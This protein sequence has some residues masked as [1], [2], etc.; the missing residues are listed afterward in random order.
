MIELTEEYRVAAKEY[1][2]KFGYGVPLSMIPP[3]VNTSD[4]IQQIREC[5]EKGKD[6]LLEHYKIVINE[7]EL[8]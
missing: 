4:L 1:R 3:T 7:E 2:K 8:F 6:T 5:I